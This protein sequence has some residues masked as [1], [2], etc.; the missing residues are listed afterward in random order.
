MPLPAPR[1]PLNPWLRRALRHSGK[2]AV[3][4][5]VVAGFTQKQ[6]LYFQLHEEYVSATPCLVKRLRRVA[7]AIGFPPDKIFLDEAAQ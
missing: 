1:R 4:I 6:H 7:E 3:S 5:A 2:R